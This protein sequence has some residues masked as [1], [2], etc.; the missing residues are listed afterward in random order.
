MTSTK[1]YS[2]TLSQLSPGKRLKFIRQKIINQNQVSFC[3]DGII[4]SGT[5][6]SIESERMKI[7]EKIAEKI[8][9]KLN[10]E[11][12][13]CNIDMFVNTSSNCDIEINSSRK[14]IIGSSMLKLEE[15]RKKT[16]NLTPIE[17][18]DDHFS[19][20]I[21]SGST[22]LA[23]EINESD[24]RKL[25]GTLCFIKGNKSGLYFLSYVDDNN[26]T[27]ETPNKKTFLSKS[28]LDFCMLFIVELIY[29]DNKICNI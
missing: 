20:F 28:I 6:K 2:E 21:P 24:F 10:L 29:Y 5:L 7:G 11:G 13:E 17:V 25:K 1:D 27:A 9:H 3:Q 14:D 4:R 15:I 8:I 22:L 19:P 23:Q 18:L 16:L 26:I 12:V